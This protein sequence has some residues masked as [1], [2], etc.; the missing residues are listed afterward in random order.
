MMNIIERMIDIIVLS[1]VVHT[2]GLVM[3]AVHHEPRLQTI[4]ELVGRMSRST[5][6]EGIVPENAIGRGEI[7]MGITPETS[8]IGITD[9]CLHRRLRLLGTGTTGLRN[10]AHL[11]PRDPPRA[12]FTIIIGDHRLLALQGR[13]RGLCRAGKNGVQVR[14]SSATR[15]IHLACRNELRRVRCRLRGCLGLCREMI[16][17]WTIHTEDL[18]MLHRHGLSNLST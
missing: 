12:S 14:R 10:R 2:A 3:L 18:L 4:G 9:R 5:I 1:E 11:P 15:I 7:G 6:L 17:R 8:V 16:W 13:G